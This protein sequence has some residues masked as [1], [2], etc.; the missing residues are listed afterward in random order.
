M[1]R[2]DQGIADRLREMLSSFQLKVFC[3]EDVPEETRA[4]IVNE[5]SAEGFRVIDEL[6]GVVR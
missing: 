2:I 1:V 5:I 3:A 4:R 6:E